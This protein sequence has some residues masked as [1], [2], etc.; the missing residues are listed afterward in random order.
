MLGEQQCMS[1]KVLVIPHAGGMASAYYEFSKY[2]DSNVD[3]VF[4]EL[5]G[6]GAHMR[7]DLYE[8]FEEAVNDIYEKN[9]NLFQQEN[10][11]LFGHSMGSWLAFELYHKIKAEGQPLPM[12]LF[13]SGNVSPFAQR[14]SNYRNMSDE[15]FIEN[16][17]KKGQTSKE[18]FI[19][20]E[21]REI[22][23]PILRSDFKMLEEY[24][25]KNGRD[26]ITS[27]ISVLCGS[28]DPLLKNGVTEWEEL[29]TKECE[30]IYFE[31]NHFYLFKNMSAIVDYIHR[32]VE[33]YNII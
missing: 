11:V 5:A 7:E 15:E 1:V 30:I 33:M 27:N 23:L 32:T 10:Y 2:A 24:V 18:I 22:F 12:H 21:L 28:E 8:D 6:R 26:P 31:G 29:T 13:F 20:R 16:I 4:V 9:I 17:F 19:N 25:P 3:F 14:F